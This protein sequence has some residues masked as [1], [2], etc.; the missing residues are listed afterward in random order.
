MR[1]TLVL[2]ALLP[3]CEA[4][5]GVD[6]R[7]RR[8]DLLD[9]VFE[10]ERFRPPPAPLPAPAPPPPVPEPEPVAMQAPEADPAPWFPEPDPV[11][12]PDPATR[13]QALLRQQPWLSRFWSEL[14]PAQQARVARRLPGDSAARWDGMGLTDRVTLLYGGAG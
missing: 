2:L 11:P 12:A 3:A 6:D 4:A 14:T 10:P 9:R 5:Q 1:W 13:T 8:I 7:L